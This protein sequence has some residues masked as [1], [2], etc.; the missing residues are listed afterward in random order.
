MAI[1]FFTVKHT[2]TTMKQTN[3]AIEIL[4]LEVALSSPR[5]VRFYSLSHKKAH[6]GVAV[7]RIRSGAGPTYC[8][9]EIRP[10]TTFFL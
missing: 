5:L 4:R 6:L 2:S 9:L 1:R 8:K 7:A 10:Q 3:K